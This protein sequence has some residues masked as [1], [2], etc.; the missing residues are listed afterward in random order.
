MSRHSTKESGGGLSFEPAAKLARPRAISKFVRASPLVSSTPPKR[1]TSARAPD[2]QRTRARAAP[3]PPL[4][5]RPQRTCAVLPRRSCEKRAAIS[6]AEAFAADSIK[7]REGIAYRSVVRRAS[8]WLSSAVTTFFTRRMIART[9][10]RKD[11]RSGHA[12]HQPDSQ[13]KLPA[14]RVERPDFI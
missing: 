8:S 7:R 5:P 3:S 2:I 6:R 14:G 12:A 9:R 10:P 11:R 4:L 1:I 13:D